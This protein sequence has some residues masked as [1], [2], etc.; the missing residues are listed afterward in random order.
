MPVDLGK[1]LE[2][3]GV[4][5]ESAGRVRLG[6]GVVGKVT[7]AFIA[8]AV[9]VAAAILSLSGQPWLIFALAL[10]FALGFFVYQRSILNFARRNPHLA[11]M[12]GAEVTDYK[13]LELAAKGIPLP[14]PSPL[15]GDPQNPVVDV[16]PGPKDAG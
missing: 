1:V 3:L 11:L 8:V 13:R 2:G 6:R 16:L 12:D 7:N 10:L 14:P 9:V 4:K 5:A 15:M